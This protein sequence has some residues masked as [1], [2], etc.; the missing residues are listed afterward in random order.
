MNTNPLQ[1]EEMQLFRSRVVIIGFVIIILFSLLTS[2]LWY[3]QILN[4]IKYTEFAEGNRIRIV[5]QPAPRGIIY[6]RNG[7]PLADNRPS[8]QLQL[9]RENTP[10]VETTILNLSKALKIPYPSLKKKIAEKQNQ[11]QFKPIV[12]VEDLE[13]SRVSLVETYQEHF[14]GTSIVVQSR[15][16]YPHNKIASHVL[17]YVGLSDEEQAEKIPKNK[18]SSGQIVGRAG[19]ELIRNEELIGVDGGKQVEV[20]H[21]GREKEILS[22]PVNPIPGQ[23]IFLTIDIRIQQLIYDL[24]KG[25]SG[26]VIVTKPRTGEILALHSSPSFNPNLFA[27]GISQKNWD[28]L[29]Q[30]SENPLENKSIQGL[31]PPGSLFKLVTGYAGL[32][33]GVIT[34]SSTYTCNG[35]FYVKGRS[36]P[37]KCWKWRQGGHGVV[38]VQGA[39]KESCNIFFYHLGQEIGVN[40]LHDYATQF[41]LGQKTGII[42]PN[43]K[44]G[45]IPNEEWKQRVKQEP[46]YAGETPPVTIG[47]GA[48]EIT[49]LQA[50][51]MIN[52][53][54]TGG[55]YV[56]PQLFLD[57]TKEVQPKQLPFSKSQ[58]HLIRSGMVAAVNAKG[59]TAW[60]VRSKKLI[61]AGKTGTAQVIGHKTLANLDEDER[62]QK[63]LQNHAWFA[64]FAPSETP[65][66]SVVVLIQHGGAGAK[67]A[68]PIAKQI[69]D[70][71]FTE[72]FDLSQQSFRDQLNHAFQQE[73]T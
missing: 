30:T 73:G 7:V 20:D 45:L 24:M 29:V 47:Q 55:M 13:Y 3:L 2:R 4:G 16:F 10:N 8:Y 51:T 9:I 39:I 17:G 57:Q 33:E 54:S 34:E 15:R 60:L 21:V 31:Y 65:E 5:A 36:T 37:F 67:D 56:P 50:I 18:R 68:G 66:I 49:P 44:K 23:E 52:L 58:L 64:A 43:E 53:I 14:P 40:A 61:I 6:D 28:R 62:N 42:L 26:A 1:P 19:I 11:A 22:K 70:Y 46:W 32:H 71:Y 59:G 69:L 63:A 72:I 25:K 12:L 27:S 38:D 41:G 35:F 48:I